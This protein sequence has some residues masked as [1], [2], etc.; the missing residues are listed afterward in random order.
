MTTAPAPLW[1]RLATRV[2]AVERL[3]RFRFYNVV[4]LPDGGLFCMFGKEMAVLRDGELRPIE[5][6]PRPCRI[7]RS[8]LALE[9]DGTLVFGEYLLNDDRTSAI[10]LFALPAGSTRVQMLR[11]FE[12]GEV[13]HIHG[14]YR[15]PYENCLWCATGDKGY[16]SR[17]LRSSD[18]F[19]TFETIG[20]GDE[21]WRCV[22]LLFTADAVYYGT[23]A[24]FHRNFIYRIDRR[25]GRRDALTDVDGPIYY[26]HAV[27]RD[28]FFGVTAELCPSQQGRSAWLW[29]VS[30]EDE[31]RSVASFEKDWM[32]WRYFL[33]GTLYFPSGPGCDDVSYVHAIALS[34]VDGYTFRLSRDIGKE[35]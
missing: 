12:V 27:G 21:S 18:R 19:A 25:T 33:P 32:P 15:D 34:G 30:P 11:R 4:P 13:R 5:G 31:C 22:S 16:E 9:P 20:A 26:S 17:I 24:E 8:C 28:L 1:K 23:D 10:D 2:R 3:L 35:E 7:M 29:H 14:V 6:L